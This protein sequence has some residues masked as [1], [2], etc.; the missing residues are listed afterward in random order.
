MIEYR[1]FRNYDPPQLVRLWNQ[2]RLGRGA[3]QPVTNDESF[4]PANFAQQY[5]DARGVIVAVDGEV[6]VGFVH[7]GFGCTDDG[8]ALDR[9][10]G[11]ICAVIVMPGYRLQGVGR[12]LVRRAELY[13]REAGATEITAGPAPRHDPF[14]FGL[15][16]GAQPVGF[17]DSDRNAAPFFTKLGYQAGSQFIVTQ[18]SMHDRDPVN[19]RLTLL[20]RKW[21]LGLADHPDPC[22]W[23]WTVRYGRLESLH[24]VLIPT[25]G[26]Q[27]VASLTVVGLDLYSRV[28]HESAIGVCDLWVAE[29]QRRQGFGQALLIETIKRLRQETVSAITA[30]VPV[31]DPS[32][33]AVFRSVGFQSIDRGVVFNAPKV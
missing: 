18:R 28:W 20:R 19:F 9:K 4:D 2:A 30:N 5:F 6:P 16:G 25:G 7:A 3:V 32:A 12:E 29:G 14:F 31:D 33:Q 15:Y 27:P 11:V 17:L 24:C 22:P 1:S 13:L 23:W 21:E 10:R 8:S 26:G